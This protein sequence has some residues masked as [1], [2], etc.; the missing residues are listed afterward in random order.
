[1]KNFD[2][3]FQF[4][5]IVQTHGRN[6]DG[7]INNIGKIINQEIINSAEN[8]I[9]CGI[10][11]D[12]DNIEVKEIEN[13]W[14]EMDLLWS[15]YW[16]IDKEDEIEARKIAEINLDERLTTFYKML[17]NVSTKSKRFQL[18]ELKNEQVTD[19]VE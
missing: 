4:K 6:D 16:S 1:M 19:I 11:F 8:I 5:T 2:C 3:H 10:D 12:R 17:E 15:G 18:I 9:G 14:F 7:A 13:G